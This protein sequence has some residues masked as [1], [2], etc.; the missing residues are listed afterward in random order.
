MVPA[1][2]FVQIFYHLFFLS[3]LSSV[4][5]TPFASTVCSVETYRFRVVGTLFVIIS[6]TRHIGGVWFQPLPVPILI[7]FVFVRKSISPQWLASS[8]NRNFLLLKNFP[9][10]F[11]TE[12]LASENGVLLRYACIS[13]AYQKQKKIY[14]LQKLFITERN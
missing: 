5:K 1:F 2:L 12:I 9:D 6:P 14:G 7:L 8:K 11:P 4:Y 10:K 3:G 13:L